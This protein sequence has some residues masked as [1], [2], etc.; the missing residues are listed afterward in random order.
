[1]RRRE[2]IVAIDKEAVLM[3]PYASRSPFHLMLAPRRPRPRF[4]DDS[5]AGAALLHD[6]LRRLTARGSARARR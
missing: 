1:M 5:P 4:E 6:A 3:A 2:R